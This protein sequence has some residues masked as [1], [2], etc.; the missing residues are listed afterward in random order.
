[1]RP[2]LGSAAT[3]ERGLIRQFYSHKLSFNQNVRSMS[4]Q[5]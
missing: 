1:M 4:I 5:L 3:S 2:F